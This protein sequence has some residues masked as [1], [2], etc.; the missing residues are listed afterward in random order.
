[1]R[2]ALAALA[3][4][5]LLAAGGVIVWSLRSPATIARITAAAGGTVMTGDGVSVRFAPGAVTADTEVRIVPRPSIEAPDGLT[6]LAEPVAI[7]LGA[8][9]LRTSATITLP[10]RAEAEDGGLV[11]VVSRDG[12]RVW[13]SEGGIVDR[14]AGTITT[15]VGHLSIFS[16]GRAVVS[17]PDPTGEGGGAYEAPEPDCGTTPSDRWT[18]HVEGA[19]ARACVAAGAADRSAL[20]RVANG[21]ASGR[22]ARLGG[23]PPLA[24]A[25]PNRASAAET[26]WRKLAEADRDYT[27]LPG[28]GVLDVSL[29][30]NYDSIDFVAR[31][32]PDVTRAEYLVDV[33][34]SAFVPAEVTVTA[35]RCALALP[36]DGLDGRLASCVSDAFDAVPVLGEGAPE[37]Q[38]RADR[39]DVRGSVIAAIR[40]LTGVVASRPAEPD[41]WRVV[42]RRSPVIP[43]KALNEPGGSIPAA[44]VSTQERLY[45]AAQRD[46]LT[47]ALPPSGLTYAGTGL[48][49]PRVTGAVAALVTTPPLRWPC[50]ETS[51]DGYVYG[52]AD[53]G[54]LTYPARLADLGLPPEDVGIVRQ[55]AAGGTDYRLCIALDG[56]W[57]SLVA[58]IPPGDFPAAE[59]RRLAGLGPVTC[60]E[61]PA[62]AFVP[63]DSVCRSIARTDLDGDGRTDTLVVYQRGD[64]WTARAVLAA[65]RTSDVLLPFDRP[66]LLDSLDLDGEPGEEVALRTGPAVR[67]LS[68]TSDGLV[69]IEQSF[70]TASTLART[71]GIG[72]SD[73]NGDGRPELVSG[74]AGFT[75]DP[76]TGAIV[77]AATVETRWTWSGKSL[78]QGETIRRQLSGPQ[79]SS[80]AAPPYLDV[81]CAWR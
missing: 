30:G 35:V 56:T 20:M 14:T 25:Q 22:F 75:R 72:C 12:H 70:A 81:T 49:G 47:D 50:D 44:V 65:G 57:T 79:A 67:L 32:G 40:G 53:S 48:T 33:M 3:A 5:V 80:A 24:V 21:S 74:S 16:A 11:T 55:T 61:T 69:L 8:G 41:E 15:T 26:A 4:V 46:T 45:A 64:R 59:A 27:F 60:G 2:V 19:A 52:L 23:Y 76:R 42:A 28:H 39:A 77:A 36:P 43:R 9:T 17:A 51:R 78:Q 71:A 34:S 10:L 7:T 29:P 1:M 68:L 31:T 38:A 6:W 58:G 66:E 62:N 63:P 18:A 13:S 54:L 37:N 73:S